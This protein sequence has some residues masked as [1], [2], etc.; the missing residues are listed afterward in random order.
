MRPCVNGS[1]VYHQTETKGETS[2]YGRMTR[3]LEPIR[4]G[5]RY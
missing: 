4:L 2:G 5:P 1:R 3:D